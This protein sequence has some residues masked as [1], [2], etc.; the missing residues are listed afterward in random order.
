MRLVAFSCLLCTLPLLAQS[1]PT[2]H[3]VRASGEAAKPD[4]AF[5]GIGVTTHAASAQAASA[6]NAEQTT[7]VLKSIGRAL[8]SGGGVKTS[9]YSLAPHY[10][11]ASGQAARLAGYDASNTVLATVDDLPVLGKIID[12]A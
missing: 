8:G 5:I 9:G 6:Q 1:P 3:F 4:R 7:Q 2:P 10:D 11:Y 12:A